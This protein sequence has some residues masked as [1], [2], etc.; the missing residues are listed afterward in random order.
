MKS[1]LFS[2]LIRVLGLKHPSLKAFAL[3]L[4]LCLPMGLVHA[5]WTEI[6]KDEDVT[7]LW[8][9]EAVKVVHVS[10]YVWTLTDYSKSAKTPGGESYQS[11]MTRWRLY[12]KNDTFVRLS[13]SFFEK[14]LGKGKEVLAVDDQEWK[15]HEYA[16]R[17]NTFLASLRKE[18]CQEKSS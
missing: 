8:D 4:A 5:E 15:N 9:K 16:I 13:V 12:C 7:H 3:C 2:P 18:V 10:R 14:P 1:Y 6:D 17:P 11:Q